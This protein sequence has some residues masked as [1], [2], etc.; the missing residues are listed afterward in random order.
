MSNDKSAA[1]TTKQS[2]VSDA[3]P[4]IDDLTSLIEVDA[5]FEDLRR[6]S[7]MGEL[8][9]KSGC[10]HLAHLYNRG[11]EEVR[12]KIVAGSGLCMPPTERRLLLEQAL[13]QDSSALV[14]HE[15]AFALSNF[16]DDEC[17]NLLCVVGLSDSNA[18][19]RHEAA[20]ALMNVGGERALPYLAKGVRDAG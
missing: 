16:S 17:G 14:R 10:E 11:S 6:T 9:A 13:R 7:Q 5:C 3:I 15:A 12:Y 4:S 19:V 8:A 20:I 18:L 1:M 2:R